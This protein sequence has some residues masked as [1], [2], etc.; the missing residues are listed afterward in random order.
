MKKLVANSC[1]LL[2]SLLACAGNAGAA[3]QV[4]SLQAKTVQAQTRISHSPIILGYYANWDVYKT[5]IDPQAATNFKFDSLQNMDK[6]ARMNS[7][8][9]AFFETAEDGTIQATDPWS[10]FDASDTQFCN[11]N[12]KICFKTSPQSLDGG[13][14]NFNKFAKSGTTSGITNRLVAFGGASHDADVERALNNPQTFANSL[15]K[16]KQTYAITGIDIDYEPLTG[17]PAAYIPKLIA[18]MSQI[19]STMGSDFMITYTII[20]NKKNIND[21]G[22]GNWDTVASIVDYINIMGYDIFGSWTDST[23]LQSPLFTV[24]GTGGSSEHSDEDAIQLLKTLGIAGQLVLGYPSYGRAVSGATSN[25][26]GQTFTNSYKGDLDDD[27]STT[28]G[29][30]NT[31]SGMITY[32]A[33]ISHGYNINY[34]RQSG[35]L[36]NG[37]INGAFSNFDAGSNGIG[38]AFVSF[39][40]VDSVADKVKYAKDNHLGGVMTWGISYDAPAANADRTPNSKSLL[41]TVISSYGISPRPVTPPSQPHFILQVSNTGP[42]QAGG[43]GSATLVV[44]G[45]Y[46]IFGNQWN[47][48]IS[49]Q[50]NQSWGTAAS[51]DSVPG[52]KDSPA[53]DGFFTNGAH[54]FTT[55]QILINSYNNNND[56]SLPNPSNQVA[57]SEGGNYKFDEGHSYNLMVNPI[58]GAC[59][60]TMM[61]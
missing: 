15:L 59:A 19:R 50:L 51:A 53:L 45:S 2:T 52:V 11:A 36:Q 13:F 42:D 58:T 5:A 35:H 30:S 4:N 38:N 39:D 32:S 33:I 61:N 8:A 47:K 44:N 24:P 9:Y 14:G 3:S 17:V 21:F 37:Y 18:L 10:D 20:P 48:P 46:K 29:L 6:L 54:S 49:P 31:C 55:S 43:Y 12:P 41:N 60:I 28:R 25:G 56:G 23:G 22:P 40:G 7:V 26:L 16:L 57:C 1:L 34:H 27:C